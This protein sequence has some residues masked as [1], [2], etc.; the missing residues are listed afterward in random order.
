[1][2]AAIILAAGE[3][4]RLGQP[5]QN[6]I[7]NGRTLLQKAVDSAQRSNCDPVI[8]VLGANFNQIKPISGVTTLY[9]KDW[10]EGMASSIRTGINEINKNVSIDKVIILLCDQP[11]V[12]T[13][14]LNSLTDK[15]IETGKPIVACVYNGTKGVPVLFARTLFAELLLLQG[16]EGA[17]KILKAHANETVTVPFEQ[18]SIDIDTL[19]DYEKLRKLSD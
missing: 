16:Q 8:V 11:F 13:E 3:S 10:E 4:S 14:L 5:K 7:F 9:N 1:M 12:S 18:G 15:Q 2:I 17:K 19:D 6:L